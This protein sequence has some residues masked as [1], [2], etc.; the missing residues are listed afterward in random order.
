MDTDICLFVYL[1]IV[2]KEV[3][4]GKAEYEFLHNNSQL[5]RILHVL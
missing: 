5:D 4:V 2:K 1:K 3:R